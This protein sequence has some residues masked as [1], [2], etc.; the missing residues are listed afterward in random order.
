MSDVLKF[1]H[2]FSCL[3]SG[4]SGS[5]KT[6]FCIRLLQNLDSLCTEIRFEWGIIWCYSER[7]AVPSRQQLPANVIFNLGVPEHFDN[8]HRP[9]LVI[10]YD[11][12]NEAFSCQRVSD[13]FTKGSHHL[14]T[15]VI[16]ITL[17]LFHQS[18]YCKHFAKRPLR[19]RAKN[20][21]DKKSFSIWPSKCTLKIVAVCS[22]L[23][24]T[25]PA[26]LTFTFFY[27]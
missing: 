12:L 3:V 18:R 10:L 4:P 14:N 7:N 11:L 9:R 17:N 6:S 1:R 19:G 23:T 24:S 22:T 16:V 15:S 26:D 20:L 5:R 25:R 21:T 27:I 2:P 13:L 8:T